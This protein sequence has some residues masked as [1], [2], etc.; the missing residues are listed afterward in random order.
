MTVSITCEISWWL[1][2]FSSDFEVVEILSLQSLLLLSLDSFGGT[3]LLSV[4]THGF[5]YVFSSGMFH[6]SNGTVLKGADLVVCLN[7]LLFKL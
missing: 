7:C 4:P 5:A 2:L 1:L 6:A 3:K